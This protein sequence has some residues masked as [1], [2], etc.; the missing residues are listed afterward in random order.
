MWP[1]PAFRELKDAVR[2]GNAPTVEI[3]GAIEASADAS[4]FRR[5]GRILKDQQ[6]S[7]GGEVVDV[8][9]FSTASVGA[10]EPILRATLATAGM[11]S[12]ISVHEYGKFGLHL[13]DPNLDSSDHEIIV[14]LLDDGIFVPRDWTGGDITTLQA[15]IK[16]RVTTVA[17]MLTAAARRR[18]ASIIVHTVPL[19]E[20]LRNSVI[21]FSAR[22]AVSRTWCELNFTLLSLAVDLQNVEIIDFVSVLAGAACQA[23]DNR[24]RRYADIPYTDDALFLL[25][26][27]IRR[28]VSAKKGRSRKALALDLDDTLWGGIIGEVGVTGVQLGGLYPGNCYRDLQR[29]VSRLRDQGVVLALVSRN[30]PEVVD[31]A[32]RDHPQMVLRADQFTAMAVNW[33][34]KTDNL[35]QI[36]AGLELSVDS[37]VFMDDSP[38]ECGSIAHEL[39]EVAIVA[40]NGEPADLV[41]ALLDRGLF[42]VVEFTETDLK[43]PQHYRARTQRIAFADGFSGSRNYLTALGTELTIEPANEFSTGRIAQLAVRTN[44]FNLTGD[45]FDAAETTA[46]LGDGRHLVI[47]CHVADRFGDEGIVG[48]AWVVCGR[49]IWQVRNLVLSCRVLGRGVE[50]AMAGWLAARA[51]DRGATTLEGRFVRS[52]RNGI[53]EDFWEQSGFVQVGKR[54]EADI[55]VLNLDSSV[56][57]LVPPWIR[58][59]GGTTR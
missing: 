4:V 31:A 11:S 5:A 38:F 18:T 48:A 39:P 21:S 7:A 55:F 13:S 45:R 15:A 2:G 52:E 37:F 25:A 41:A 57:Q 14:C 29:T 40:A 33:S 12:S 58:L 23:I 34:A 51:F 43:R 6:H 19:P 3:L 46:M 50:T 1:E 44:Q 9:V 49:D 17:D 47:S 53:A 28:F 22:A 26:K 35:R 42:D 32:L 27:E 56:D 36:A 20:E 30:I 16:E 59:Q 10:L 54:A 8:A 24:L